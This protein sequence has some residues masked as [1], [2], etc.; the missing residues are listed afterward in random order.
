MASIKH[1]TLSGQMIRAEERQTSHSCE[2]TVR[3]VTVYDRCP[4]ASR[5]FPLIFN[6]VA[7]SMRFIKLLKFGIKHAPQ[8]AATIDVNFPF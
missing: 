8:P 4:L 7:S 6:D 1:R 3:L 2:V 5:E